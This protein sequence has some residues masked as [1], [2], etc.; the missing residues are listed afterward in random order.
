M[1][2]R[3]A[4][5]S[6]SLG[7]PSIHPLPLRLDQ[8]AQHNLDIELFHDDILH[9]ANDQDHTAFPTDALRQLAAASVIRS[10]CDERRIKIVSL[11]PFRHYEGLLDRAKHR[12]RINEIKLWIKM[13]QVLNTD[14][15]GIPSTFL[16][17]A[18]TSGDMDLIVRD[19]R[20]VAELGARS[21]IR[22][23]YEALAWGTHVATWEKAWDAVRQVDRANFGLCLDSFNLA[24]RVYADPE[25]E[26]GVTSDA[27]AAMQASLER[28]ANID[29]EKLF[30]V[31]VVDAE[32][33]DAPLTPASPYYVSGQASRLS[34]SRN[35]RLFYGEEEMGGYLPVRDILEVVFA[36][37]AFR[38]CVS[39]ELFNRSLADPDPGTPEKH[40]RRAAASF[41][42]LVAEFWTEM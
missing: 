24:G 27:V 38:G 6:I 34:W 3:P 25:A 29:A 28:L 15:I 22:F 7:S 35:C 16:P 18:E 4:V 20:E 17:E 11:Q 39:A 36:K 42:K 41:E 30:W 40:A 12:Q 37:L 21:G 2:C 10:L 33:L 32:R 19:L 26:S 5:S 1:A 8:A 14:L 13:A 9:L 31:Q 23:S